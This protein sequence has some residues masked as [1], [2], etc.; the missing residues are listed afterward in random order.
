MRARTTPGWPC[1]QASIDTS[2]NRSP[3]RA[4]STRWRTSRISPIADVSC[5]GRRRFHPPQIGAAPRSCVTARAMAAEHA[6][7]QEAEPVEI[8]DE[9][10]GVSGDD[11]VEPAPPSPQ[12]ER[13]GGARADFVAAL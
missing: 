6:L 2:P 5:G 12:L 11:P 4:P 7:E 13:L 1:W 3:P 10:S 8:L 9:A